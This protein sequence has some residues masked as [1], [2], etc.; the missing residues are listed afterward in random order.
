MNVPVDK[1]RQH[2]TAAQIDGLGTFTDEC[3][4]IPVTVRSRIADV[5]RQDP[6]AIAMKSLEDISTSLDNM[7]PGDPYL[8]IL[9]SLPIAAD[10]EVHSIVAVEGSGPLEQLS[11]GV[12]EYPSAHIKVGTELVVRSGHSAQGHPEAIAEIRRILRE[13][14]SALEAAGP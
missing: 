11:D 8:E 5:L 13:H 14:L 9:R 2:H 6:D 3:I 12:V 10:V 4:T 1:S 7:R